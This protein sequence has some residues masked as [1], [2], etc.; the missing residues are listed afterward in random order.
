MESLRPTGGED[1]R[2]RTKALAEADIRVWASAGEVSVLF[3]RHFLL[4]D[5]SS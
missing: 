2:Q 4:R 1:N 5:G 3:K